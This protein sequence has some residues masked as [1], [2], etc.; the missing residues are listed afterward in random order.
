[1]F[2]RR[3]K[4]VREDSDET[5]QDLADLLGV[6]VS[7]IRN[8]EKDRNEPDYKVL[9]KICDHYNVTSDFLLGRAKTDPEYEARRI[10]RLLDSSEQADVRAYTD[11]LLWKRQHQ[12]KK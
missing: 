6:S 12:P 2:G 3:L 1:M 9:V 8:W 4:D 11:F 10:Q 5:Q 7:T